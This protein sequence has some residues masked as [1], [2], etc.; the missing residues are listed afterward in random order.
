MSWLD[1]HLHSSFSDDGEFPPE[2]LA[3]LCRRAGIRVAA[4]AD[5]NTTRGVLAMLE[6]GRALG[7][8]VVPAV[9]LD[10]THKG[11]DLHL[12]GYWID[13]AHP[14]FARA[15]ESVLSQEQSSAER[16]IELVRACGIALDRVAVMALSENGAVTGEMLAE[17]ALAM[18]ENADN[19]LLSPYRPG[20]ARSDNPYVNFYW[21]FCAQGK[22]AYIPIRFPSLT[23]A[24]ALVR[25]AGGLPVLAH[26]GN[27]IHEDTAL[28]QSI[29][30]CGVAGLEA[31]SSYHTPAQTGFYLRQADALGLAVSCG[32][33]FHG[34]IKPAIRL[35]SAGSGGRE[36]A[37]LGE[38]RKKHCS[39]EEAE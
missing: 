20:G 11:V 37:L 3:L 35:G 2:E 34:K 29:V 26:P 5:H 39:L 19:P 4:L 24:V 28:L 32:S 9:E 31:Y 33:D 36:E 12:L 8:E 22:P 15:E 13:P 16:R 18:P 14:G 10:C 27:N 25:E 23:E 17:V 7:V 1:L 6:A 21:D 38:L 30:R